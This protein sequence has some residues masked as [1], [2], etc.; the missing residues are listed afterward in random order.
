MLDIDKDI[1]SVLRYSMNKMGKK[2]L[3]NSH[4]KN[5][6]VEVCMKIVSSYDPSFYTLSK[7]S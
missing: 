3:L 2:T 7:P 1:C 4:T 6:V 5:T